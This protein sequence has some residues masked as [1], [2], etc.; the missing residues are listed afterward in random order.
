MNK[1]PAHRQQT[2]AQR[3]FMSFPSFNGAHIS[4]RKKRPKKE[5]KYGITISFN[6]QYSS[7]IQGHARGGVVLTIIID[8]GHR[9]KMD[10]SERG[11]ELQVEPSLRE[12]REGRR[13]SFT[14][15]VRHTDEHK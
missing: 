10:R 8:Y 6:W 4:W 13:M 1:L 9:T 2:D 5:E 15:K 11:V 7:A 14:Y 12:E 3:F